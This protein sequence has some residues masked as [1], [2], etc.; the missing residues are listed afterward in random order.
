MTMRD[1]QLAETM[2][3]R[4]YHIYEI[5]V[6]SLAFCAFI[7]AL[8][9]FTGLGSPPTY[10]ASLVLYL[11][12]LADFC[13]ALMLCPTWAARRQYVRE[14]QWELIALIP[15]NYFV[16]D[17]DLKHLLQLLRSIAY[18]MRLMNRARNFFDTCGFKY[19]IAFFLMLI[20][21]GT[22]SFSKHEGLDMLNSGWWAITT[23]TTVGYGDIVPTTPV[24][25]LIGMGLML[26]GVIFFGLITSTITAYITRGQLKHEARKKAMKRKRKHPVDADAEP[27]LIRQRVLHSIKA[28]LDRLDEL[29]DAD[30]DAMARVL[31]SLRSPQDSQSNERTEA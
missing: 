9:N 1:S 18:L 17:P 29:S 10:L 26:I 2:K 22:W 20:T 30:I 27:Q 21:L 7:L 16:P 31:R 11:Y 15:A 12:F 25:K 14:H 24:G 13:V 19:A 28:D 4:W 3:H 6:C 5:V 23:V 8:I